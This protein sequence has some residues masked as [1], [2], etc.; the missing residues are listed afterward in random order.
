MDQLSDHEKE[1]IEKLRRAMY[2]RTLSEQ[3]KERERR[4]LNE[5][6][7]ALDETWHD[8]EDGVASMAVAPRLIGATRAFLKVMLVG[9]GVFFLG[10]LAFLGYYFFLGP[11]SMTVAPRNIDIT[12]VGPLQVTGGEP[13]TLQVAI[14]NK[15]RAAL[16]LADLVVKYPDGSRSVADSSK[17]PDD[18]IA[19]G[20]IE[21][22]GR[23][24]GT[25]S[26]VLVGKGGDRVVIPVELEYRIQGSN[27][28]YVARS[29]YALTFVT[30]PITITVEGNPEVVSGQTTEVTVTL[31]SNA[32][33]PIEGVLITGEFPFGFTFSSSD[34]SPLSEKLWSVGTIR[35]GEKKVITLRGAVR[36]ER[37]DER[38]FRF[39]VGTK[40]NPKDSGPTVVLGEQKLAVV[41]ARP[42]IGLTISAN[43]GTGEAAVVKPGETVS[44]TVDW[45]NNLATPITNAVIVARLSGMPDGTPVKTTDGFFRSSDNVVLWD[46]STTGGTLANLAPGASGSVSF[47]FEM[48]SSEDLAIMRDPRLV[49][50]VNAGGSRLSE[51][52]V[53]ENLQSVSMQTIKVASDLQLIA[54]G[55][56]YTNPF[57]SAGPLPPQVGKET[58]YAVVFTVLNTTNKIT[59]ASISAELPSY[60]RWTGIYSPASEKIEFDSRSGRI[61]WRIGDIEPGVGING[62]APR[63]AA[64]AIGFSPSLGQVGSQ[65]M[66]VDTVTLSGTDSAT[67]EKVTRTTTTQ[68]TT[69]LANVAQSSTGTKYTGEAGFTTANATVVK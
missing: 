41:V 46:K 61:V 51:K 45:K 63:Q 18:R 47:S 48:P 22:G 20:A 42:F 58:T 69:N 49:V 54:Q 8:E 5:G 12:V 14:V 6:A 62:A 26:A 35:P 37:G 27:S 13:V 60:V 21:P 28:I 9:A 11:G 44:V 52:G 38:T 64:I 7:P 3:L 36:G 55:L 23:R 39:V 43:K 50:T 29:E 19:L 40:K 59:D 56:Y 1:R 16:E 67:G 34:P 25:V 4:N 2:S 32:T 30:S 66:L 15:N 57:T 68:I 31:T 53:P 10:A 17:N 33:T 24:Q 65:P